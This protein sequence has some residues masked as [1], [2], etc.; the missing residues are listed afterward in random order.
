MTDD[1]N[2]ESKDFSPRVR[3][4]SSSSL[5]KTVFSVGTALK[6]DSYTYGFVDITRISSIDAP[7]LTPTIVTPSD[8]IR[9]VCLK[10][11]SSESFPLR[12]TR[13]CRKPW[14]ARLPDSFVKK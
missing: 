13:N 5:S 12:T 7:K 8:L 10:T 14:D 6:V 4:I 9:R 11:G 1:N 2:N 3:V